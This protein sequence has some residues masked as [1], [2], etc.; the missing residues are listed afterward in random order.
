[1]SALATATAP[2]P[3]P[4]AT[5]PPHRVPLAVR[6]ALAV[7]LLAAALAT[8]LFV[9]LQPRAA[10]AFERLG[11]DFLREGAAAMHD[12]AYEQSQHNSDLL[13]DLLRSS[14]DDR[15]RALA[16][17]R[18]QDHGGDA[19]AIRRAIAA[20]DA[21]R[22]AHEQQNVVA[23]SAA[24]QRRAE[25]TIDARLRALSAAQ[26][27]R[28]SEVVA[29][30]RDG[31]LAMIGLTLA[32]V[33]AVLGFG[34]HH[35]VVL[36][37]RRLRDAAR[38]IA[39]GDLDTARLRVTGDEVGD[40][41][42]D[43]ATM[44]GQ[45][46]YARAEQQRLSEGLAAQVAEKTAHL[47]QALADLRNSHHQL[48]K[49]ERLAA[50]GTLAGGVAHEFH[51][52]IGGIRG[53]AAELAAGEQEPA[54]AET[55]AVITR[56]ADRGSVIV[57]Q[58][59]RFARRSLDRTGELDPGAVLEDALRLCEPAARRQSVAVQRAF[60]PGLVVWGDADGL[61]QVAVNLVINALQAMPKGG[62][63]QLQSERDGDG[64]RLTIADTGTGIAGEHLPHVFEPF[65]TTKTTP[66]GEGKTGSGLG[67][68][69][70]YGIVTAHGGRITVA[71]TPGAGT[72]FTIWLPRRPP[73]A[74]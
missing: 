30:V 69:V 51:N 48:A 58:L 47:E 18:L 12:L 33:L 13:V 40:L 31:H 4:D 63:L 10:R 35:S 8:V 23:L 72:T 32:I 43:F 70:S 73:G 34:L 71:S 5:T 38:R 6:L 27:V 42:R 2:G 9:W 17:L 56:A 61:Y 55:L 46:R 68:S 29:D 62:T 7:L 50:L 19:E 20:D 26:A 3:G 59:L 16:E 65:F 37:V 57:Q 54:R 67:L 74:A 53:C 66:D 25:A 52:V 28:T 22:S 14:V 60:A 36:P 24:G 41:A 11:A 64:A 45:L 44:T 1:M 49:A 21:R 39:A 15:S